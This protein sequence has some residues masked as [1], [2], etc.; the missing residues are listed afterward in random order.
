MR[1]LLFLLALPLLASPQEPRNLSHLDPL[2]VSQHLAFYE[3]YPDTPAGKE[4][5]THAWQLLNPSRVELKE[6][7]PLPSFDIQAIISL[8]TRQPFSAPVTLSE[9][10]LGAIDTISASLSNRSLKGHSVWT[11]KR[12]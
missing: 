12:C 8:V 3:L 6:P 1:S 11:K 9:E 7:L 2:S 10:Q 5:L 4:A